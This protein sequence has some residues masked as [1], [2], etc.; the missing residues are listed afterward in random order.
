MLKARHGVVAGV[1]KTAMPKLGGCGG[2]NESLSLWGTAE[3]VEWTEAI[4]SKNH[5]LRKKIL[6]GETKGVQIQ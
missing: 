6:H 5:V 2:G 1:S 4:A 3:G